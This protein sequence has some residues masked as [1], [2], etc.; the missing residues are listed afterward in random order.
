MSPVKNASNEEINREQKKRTEERK[1]SANM[2]RR[3]TEKM[4]KLDILLNSYDPNNRLNRDK[5]KSNFLNFERTLP[6]R[7]LL[8]NSVDQFI[9][10]LSLDEFDGLLR[11]RLDKETRERLNQLLGKSS[12]SGRSL[13]FYIQNK[14]KNNGK[15]KKFNIYLD[16]LQGK[17]RLPS[18][19]EKRIR[20]KIKNLKIKVDENYSKLGNLDDKKK[21]QLLQNLIELGVLKN[22]RDEKN[23]ATNPENI[24]IMKVIDHLKSCE[25]E[26]LEV[27]LRDLNSKMF[28]L[29]RDYSRIKDKV[30]RKKLENLDPGYKI[31]NLP[32]E[33]KSNN[34]VNKSIEGIVSSPQF[35]N[36]NKEIVK[37]QRILTKTREIIEESARKNPFKK[38]NKLKGSEAKVYKMTFAINKIIE[39]IKRVLEKAERKMKGSSSSMSSKLGILQ[40]RSI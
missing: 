4:K 1:K 40:Q 15:L 17:L 30:V 21:Q 31:N 34:N 13:G 35:I 8:Q 6:N 33:K 9:N 10:S 39:E 27:I 14:K 37:Y 3:Q 26:I 29:Q 18:A 7:S 23:N 32:T 22:L 11:D 2:A 28:Q 38:I 36:L 16:Y 25:K 19:E 20:D 12:Y 24:R 5:F